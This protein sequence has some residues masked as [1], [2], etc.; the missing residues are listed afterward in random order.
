MKEYVVWVGGV[1]VNSYKL[2]LDK[3][4]DLCDEYIA[5]GYDDASIE[6]I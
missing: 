6:K 5:D 1:I 4:E 3:A 2:T